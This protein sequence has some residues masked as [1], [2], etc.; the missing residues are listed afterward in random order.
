[1]IF[2]MD[3]AL[4]F[5]GGVLYEITAPGLTEEKAENNNIYEFT[6]VAGEKILKNGKEVYNYSKITRDNLPKARICSIIFLCAKSLKL[7]Y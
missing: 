3:N 1:M 2:G 6:D 4:L 5:L 7:K